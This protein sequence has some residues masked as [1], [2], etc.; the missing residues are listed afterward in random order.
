MLLAI[1]ISNLIWILP[2]CIGFGLAG[3]LL[4][5]AKLGKLT[6]RVRQLE[7]EMMQ[8]HA[9]ILALE[10]ENAQL[11]DKLKNYQAVPV[12]PITG[13]PKETPAENLPDVAAR[14][15]LLGSSAKKHS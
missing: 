4:R 10:R 7:A 5:G 13:A 9:E 2:V 14:K 8:N 11:A 15:K 1:V 3:Y 12:I 6:K